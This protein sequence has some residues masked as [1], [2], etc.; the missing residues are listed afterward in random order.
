VTVA[1]LLFLLI[2]ILGGVAGIG[3][4]LIAAHVSGYEIGAWDAY[5]PATGFVPVAVNTA[6]ADA[7]L[8]PHVEIATEGPLPAGD[9]TAYLTLT[10][11][12]DGKQER[13]ETIDLDKVEPTVT[14]PQAGGVVYR[15]DL[16]AFASVRSAR[17]EFRF[18][19]GAAG[20]DRLRGVRFTLNAGAFDVDPRAV[21]VGYI[22]MAI[23]AVGLLLSFRKRPPQNPNSQPPA[24]RW[25]RDAGS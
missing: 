15:R 16:P 10:V 6:P 5:S 12:A 13:A 25:G 2:F 20:L 7:P 11:D 1:R 14:S 19:E 24:T 3:Y 4:P 9:R 8:F 23:G 17:Y 22:L 21:P 18:G